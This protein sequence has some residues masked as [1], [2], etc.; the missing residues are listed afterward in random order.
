MSGSDIF[1]GRTGWPAERFVSDEADPARI[2]PHPHPVAA[3]GRSEWDGRLVF[4]G[5]ESDLDSPGVMEGAVGA[6]QRAL[7]ELG[8]VV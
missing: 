2:H 4:A 1:G 6:G 3:L 8:I 5:T 7:R